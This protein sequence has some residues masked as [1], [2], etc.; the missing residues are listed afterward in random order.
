MTRTSPQRRFALAAA[1]LLVVP[2]AFAADD[3]KSEPAQTEATAEA[4]EPEGEAP[5]PLRVERGRVMTNRGAQ[6]GEESRQKLK[7]QDGM[8]ITNDLL[9][10][11]VGPAPEPTGEAASSASAAG[12][13][14]SGSAAPPAPPAAT[15]LQAMADEQAAAATRQ[16]EIQKA[17]QE[18]KTA[19]DKLA[20]LE[21]QL[22][23]TVNPFSKRPQLSDEEK[24]RRR[25]SG[26][27]ASA[28]NERTKELVEAA[29]EEVRAAEE[30]LAQLR[31]GS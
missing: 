29:R 12:E 30:R 2:A 18:L 6:G 13:P 25:T 19:K 1:L 21:T 28:R 17:E 5:A 7:L 23:A 27:T 22:L 3:E 20:N 16:R 8:V 24:E 31:S 26:E 11:I 10:R 14:A 4:T 15:P 9:E